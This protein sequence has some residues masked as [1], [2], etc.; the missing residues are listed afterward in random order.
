MRVDLRSDTVTK[1]CAEMRRA[2]A[3]AEVGDDMFGEDPTVARLEAEVAEILG[4]EAGLFVPSGTMAN[5]IALA[6]LSRPGQE[7]IVEAGAHPFHYESGGAAVISGLTLRPIQGVRGFL[8]PEQIG[9]AVSP[10]VPWMAPTALLSVE[11][12]ANRAGGAVLGAAETAGL[13]AEARRLGLG[14]H[15]DGA[16]LWHAAVATGSAEAALAAG[17]D[18]VCVCF[19]KG[20]GAPVGSLVAGSAPL[21]KEARR[22]R[23]MLGGAMRQAGVLA[24]AARIGVAQRARLAEDH[25]EMRRLWAGL[26]LAGWAAPEPETNMLY[27]PMP[28][29]WAGRAAELAA[30][31]KGEGVYCFA[32]SPEAVRLVMHRD[33]DRAG[34]DL[35]TSVF[36]MLRGLSQG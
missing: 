19:S 15:L 4:K 17:F 9:P 35:A 1:P 36:R 20:L 28:P 27:V 13:V 5:Q 26:A 14:L 12:T 3:E 7:A 30:R 22:L 34:V 33:V 10:D 21:V 8:R 25:A 24:A 16:R 2:M 31:L 18:L 32:L 23:K 11:N 29:E 6:C